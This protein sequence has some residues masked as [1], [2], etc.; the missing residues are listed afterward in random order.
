M[1]SIP[2]LETSAIGEARRLATKLAR[3]SE[4]TETEVANVAIIVAEIANNLIKHTPQGGEIILYLHK[5]ELQTR[6]INILGLDKGPGIMQLS[7]CLKDGYSTVGTSGT[8]LGAIRRLSTHFD[9][10]TLPQQG[11]VVWS[12]LISKN[13]LTFLGS[14]QANLAG[15]LDMGVVCVPLKGELV[16]GDNW[17]VNFCAAKRQFSYLVVDGLGHGEGAYEAAKE[18]T[19]IFQVNQEDELSVE[20]LFQKIHL[21]LSKTR[22]AAV[23]ISRIHFDKQ[24]LEYVGVGN[25]ATV[26]WSDHKRKSLVSLNGIVGH[27]LKKIKPFSYPLAKS[28]V[29][30]MYSDGIIS[31]WDLEKYPMLLNKPANIIAGVLYRDYKRG[32]DDATLMVVKKVDRE[33]NIS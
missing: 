31:H 11:T 28:Y 8:G 21:G 32:R 10:Y 17:A 1:L 25:I 33:I 14:N 4:F 20:A 12:Q 16:C 26:L 5:P 15:G 3:E 9:I 23:A 2:V 30:I 13:A 7:E 6:A 18:A 29:F 27:G 19:R 24:Q 22:G